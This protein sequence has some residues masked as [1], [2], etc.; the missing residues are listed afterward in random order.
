MGLVGDP[1]VP[2]LG[3]VQ[4][5]LYVP[6]LARAKESKRRRP[7]LRDPKAAEIV[8]AI[9]PDRSRF[10]G[11]VGWF[12][13]LR[14]AVFDHWVSEF[15]AAHPAGTVVELGSG[16]NARF[17]RVDNGRVAWFDL[18]LPD[19]VALRRR[20]FADTDRRRTIAASVLDD[21]WMDTVAGVAGPYLF[22]S[23]GVLVYLD[24]DQVPPALRRIATRFPGARLAIDTYSAAM[25]RRQREGTAARQLA[26]WQWACDD[27]SELESLGLRVR[28]TASYRHVP[29]ALRARLPLRYRTLLPLVDRMAG[30]L[31][32]LT[33]FDT[34]T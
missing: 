10:G 1:S 34:T 29:A 33:L 6:L 4:Q 22:V 16:L 20:F 8:D 31:L 11:G 26:P 3:D 25:V 7:L 27:P 13:V 30:G 2:E 17:E 19:T 12:T 5:T 15:L 28:E 23:E 18:D 32:A 24:P 14:T 9:D 21:A